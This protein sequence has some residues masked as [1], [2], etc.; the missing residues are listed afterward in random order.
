MARVFLRRPCV[1]RHTEIHAV[2]S[3]FTERENVEMGNFPH[4]NHNPPPDVFVSSLSPC[5]F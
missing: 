5:K 3:D 1:P 4:L 2:K